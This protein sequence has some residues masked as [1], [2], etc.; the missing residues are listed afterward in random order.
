MALRPNS[1]VNSPRRPHWHWASVSAQKRSRARTAKDSPSAYTQTNVSSERS[2]Q[3][4]RS[5]G[6]AGVLKWNTKAVPSLIHGVLLL[7]IMIQP[8]VLSHS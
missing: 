3:E 2:M 5:V 7:Y 4:I 1:D 6:T 8:V